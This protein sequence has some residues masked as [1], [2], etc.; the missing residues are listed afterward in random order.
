MRQITRRRQVIATPGA[1]D[2]ADRMDRTDR[3]DGA[4]SN[5]NPIPIINRSG[6]LREEG[7]ATQ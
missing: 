5:W 2:G 3:M 6:S 7:T 4:L 1:T